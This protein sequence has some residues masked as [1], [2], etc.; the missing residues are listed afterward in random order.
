[1]EARLNY[2]GTNV[3]IDLAAWRAMV[4]ACGSPLPCSASAWLIVIA[5]WLLYSKSG[6]EVLSAPNIQQAPWD[7]SR[8]GAMQL[9]LWHQKVVGA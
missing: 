2:Y 7:C 9:P 6:V 4:K 1:M 8:A 3:A 5:E